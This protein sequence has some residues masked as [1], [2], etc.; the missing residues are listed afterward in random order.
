MSAFTA[1]I[2]ILAT[3]IAGLFGVSW[4]ALI[5][6]AAALSTVSLVEHHHYRARFSAAGLSDVY[7][8]FALSNIGTSL[9]ASTAAYAMGVIVRFVAFA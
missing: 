9:L 7:Q 6:G 3:A 5:L 1:F 8:S 2:T 4:V